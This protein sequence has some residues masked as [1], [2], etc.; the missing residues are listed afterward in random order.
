MRGRKNN[1]PTNIKDWQV[2]IF[3]PFEQYW[4]RIRGLNT[5]NYATDSDTEDGSTAEEAWEEPYITKRKASLS[6]EG[7]P[8]VDAATGA[9]DEGQ[10]LLNYYGKQIRCEADALLRFA[11]PWGHIM[12]FYCQVTAHE[13]KADKSGN[14]VSWD[15]AQVG[16]SETPPYIQATGVA[17]VSMGAEPETIT[18]DIND[19]PRLLQ[20]AFTPED[21]SN[22]RYTINAGG[23]VVRV[24]SISDTGFTIAPLKVG[25]ASVKITSINNGHTD[26]VMVNVTN[27]S[28]P[29]MTGVLGVGMLGAMTL[30]RAAISA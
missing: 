7:K 10:E 3:N 25:T 11:D 26:I 2:S 13:V 30:G 21:T 29:F 28:Q 15:L 27:N 19:A 9:V 5:L 24:G 17:I 14:T 6:L 18:L 23:H 1:C 20:V 22:K 8:A 12:E 4:V 16:Q